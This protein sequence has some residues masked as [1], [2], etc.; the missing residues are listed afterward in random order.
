MLNIKAGSKGTTNGQRQQNWSDGPQK[1]IRP[2]KRLRQMGLI[3][4][5]N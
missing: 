3:G 1:F 2:G 5:G 4:G